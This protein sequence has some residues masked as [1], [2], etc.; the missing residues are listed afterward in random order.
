MQKKNFLFKFL[1]FEIKVKMLYN[2]QKWYKIVVGTRWK[3]SSRNREQAFMKLGIMNK[4]LIFHGIFFF[5]DEYNKFQNIL[6]NSP[7]I[8]KKNKLQAWILKL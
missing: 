6:N 5:L 4:V 1:I 3:K 8:I 2:S 7:K